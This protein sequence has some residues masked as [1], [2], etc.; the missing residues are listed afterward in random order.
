[1][2]VRTQKRYFC[3]CSWSP[4]FS[5]LGRD[6]FF[7]KDD[8][9]RSKPELSSILHLLWI[10]EIWYAESCLLVWHNHHVIL[11]FNKE[12]EQEQSLASALAPCGPRVGIPRSPTSRASLWYANPTEYWGHWTLRRVI[13]TGHDYVSARLIGKGGGGE[14]L[15]S[16]V[17]WVSRRALVVCVWGVGRVRWLACVNLSAC[18]NI[19]ISHILTPESIRCRW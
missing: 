7:C 12:N 3:G 15:V 4:H 14:S 10:R 9:Q 13:N 8:R 19:V 18:C 17:N 16:Q 11:Y 5:A 6:S 2:R 1:M